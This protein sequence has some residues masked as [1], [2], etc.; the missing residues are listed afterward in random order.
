MLMTLL[1]MSV[2]LLWQGIRMMHDGSI[3]RQQ[4]MYKVIALEDLLYY[5][6]AQIQ[7][8]HTSAQY[9]FE[10]WPLHTQ[11]LWY[12]QARVTIKVSDCY[13]LNA[14][15][16]DKEHV[17]LHGSCKLTTTLENAERIWFIDAWTIE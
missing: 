12:W 5:A 17:V 4:Y 8:K 1:L 14:V 16:F 13:Q 6:I 10:H 11:A 9:S 2:T 7:K 15:L 3:E